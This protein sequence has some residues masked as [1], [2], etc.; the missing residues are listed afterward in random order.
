MNAIQARVNVAFPD[1]SLKVD[2]ELPGQGITALFGPSGAGKTTLLRAIAGLER[3]H[4]SC[5]KI[6]GETWQDDSLD[7]FVATHQRPLG[8]VFQDVI[9]FEHLDVRRNLEYGMKRVPSKDRKISLDHAV[10]LLGIAH[11]MERQPCTLSG[12]ERQ[13][14]GIARALATSPRILLMDEPL[15]ALDLPLAHGD[16]AAAIID[17]RVVELDAAFQLACVEFAGGRILLPNNSIHIGQ[18]VRLRIQARDVSLT[19]WRQ[20]GTSILNSIGATVADLSDDAVGQVM[21]GLD[22]NGTRLLCRITK[23]SAHALG[24]APGK[25]LFAQVK[26]VA[27]I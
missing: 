14:V 3:A 16:A 17:G 27:V 10:D 15:A 7:I 8:F 6:G 24:L 13:R 20:S 5:I 23:K 1:Y 25:T 2:L 26:G 11:L 22:A 18:R 4:D 9:L 12:G 21:V 19:L